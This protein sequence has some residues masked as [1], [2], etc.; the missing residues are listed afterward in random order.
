MGNPI[1]DVENPDDDQLPSGTVDT[2]RLAENDDLEEDLHQPPILREF[3][4]K[5]AQFLG[6]IN[7]VSRN[8][9]LNRYSSFF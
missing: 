6:A 9:E 3:P 7:K 8:R 1:N 5:M 2:K 4:N